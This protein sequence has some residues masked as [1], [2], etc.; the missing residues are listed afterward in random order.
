MI[1]TPAMTAGKTTWVRS[2]PTFAGTITSCELSRTRNKCGK[3][4]RSA[5]DGTSVVVLRFV[6]LNGFCE[7]L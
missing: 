7:R 4:T 1:R 5:V 6:A 2:A 3:E